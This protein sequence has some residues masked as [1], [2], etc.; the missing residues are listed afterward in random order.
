MHVDV[1]AP[2]APCK[3]PGVAQSQRPWVGSVVTESGQILVHGCLTFQTRLNV[4][5]GPRAQTAP[6]RQTQPTSDDMPCDG[7]WARRIET[8][9]EGCPEGGGDMLEAPAFC[10][11]SLPHQGNTRQVIQHNSVRI[12]R[13]CRKHDCIHRHWHAS[14]RASA[15]SVAVGHFATWHQQLRAMM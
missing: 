1:L 8:R 12:R 11:R 5:P 14:R 9:N 10:E 15:G 2:T 7:V 4:R 6:S 3:A 13:Q